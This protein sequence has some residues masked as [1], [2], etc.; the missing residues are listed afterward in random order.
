MEWIEEVL[1]DE[2]V[3]RLLETLEQSIEEETEGALE[4][5]W[6][7][8]LYHGWHEPIFQPKRTG[9]AGK[10]IT[11]APVMINDTLSADLMGYRNMVLSQYGSCLQM[12]QEKSGMLLCVRA[13]YGVG[14]LPSLFGAKMFVMAREQNCLPNSLP[15]EK[16]PE[17][18]IAGGVPDLSCGLG[19]SVF[20]MQEL[21][22]QIGMRFPKI[23]R[24]VHIYHPDLQ[25]PMDVMELLM[26]SECFYML[27]DEPEMS[28]KLL[29]LICD[30]YESF[31]KAWWRKTPY[32]GK[33]AVHWG[34]MHRGGIML[35]NDSAMN[36]SPEMFEEYVEPADRR[37]MEKLGG[38]CVHFCG[39]GDHYIEKS[40]SIPGVS[41]I[42][43]SQPEYNDMEKIY[44]ATVD[45]GIYIL[46]LDPKEAFRASSERRLWGRVSI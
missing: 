45:R 26:G 15:V 19:A 35:R 46:N 7:T 30:T 16:S 32:N 33:D 1:K 38:G 25:G 44:R 36:L 41:A 31:M 10:P 27:V 5:D 9:K 6:R 13:N 17:D 11:N 3:S 42:N 21:F 29:E 23:G 18:L 22:I 12:L 40:V 8:F 43:L 14:I 28:H 4:E 39:R 20:A 37:L 34:L 2:E 24:Y